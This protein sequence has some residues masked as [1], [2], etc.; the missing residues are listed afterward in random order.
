MW[1]NPQSV[2]IFSPVPAYL[3]LIHTFLSRWMASCVKSSLKSYKLAPGLHSSEGILTILTKAA[4]NGLHG[5]NIKG[6][7]VGVS[8]NQQ[9][10]HSAQ[11]AH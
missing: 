10:I 4:G 3:W 7:P 2:A 9:H 11:S 5:K 6:T 8:S 1:R